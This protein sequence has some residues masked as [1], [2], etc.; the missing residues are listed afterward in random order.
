ME[1]TTFPDFLKKLKETD[2]K[3]YQEWVKALI[4]LKNN[5]DSPISDEE[6]QARC[7]VH[8]CS[9]HF[10]PLLIDT[11]SVDECLLCHEKFERKE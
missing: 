8:K 6:I 11:W 4:K 5:Q 2:P 3:E 10:E 9:E 1:K 7:L